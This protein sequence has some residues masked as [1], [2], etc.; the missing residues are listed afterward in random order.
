MGT[1]CKPHPDGITCTQDS[2]HTQKAATLHTYKNHHMETRDTHFPCHLCGKVYWHRENLTRH[3]TSIHYAG[4]SHH[5][6]ILGCT[7]KTNRSDSLKRH[8]LLVHG[9]SQTSKVLN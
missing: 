1:N 6:S 3:I 5:C 2:V 7:F 8:L 9:V 4:R